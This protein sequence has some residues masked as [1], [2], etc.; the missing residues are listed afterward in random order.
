M[1]LGLKLK[2]IPGLSHF[3]STRPGHLHD[4]L[5]PTV[6]FPHGYDLTS[7][8]RVQATYPLLCIPHGSLL[9]SHL[10]NVLCFFLVSH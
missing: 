10:M 4:S 8:V 6:P 5:L 9:S 7:A 3:Q 2:V 1:K